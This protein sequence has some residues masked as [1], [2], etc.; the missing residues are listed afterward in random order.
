MNT[1]ANERRGRAVL[2]RGEVDKPIMSVISPFVRSIDTASAQHERATVRGAAQ[3][4]AGRPNGSGGDDRKDL[5]V[6]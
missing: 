4:E 6:T 5:E 1:P 3:T 2:W